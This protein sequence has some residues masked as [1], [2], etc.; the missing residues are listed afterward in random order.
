[1][2]GNPF[3][4]TVRHLDLP[5]RSPAIDVLCNNPFG[6]ILGESTGSR[7]SAHAHAQ[8]DTESGSLVFSSDHGRTLIKLVRLSALLRSRGNLANL[9]RNIAKKRCEQSE[10]FRGSAFAEFHSAGPLRRKRVHARKF[11]PCVKQSVLSF[12]NQNLSA[13]QR[14]CFRVMD[15]ESSRVARFPCFAIEDFAIRFRTKIDLFG[16]RITE[17]STPRRT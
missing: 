9:V 10:D 8:S 12:N 11:G 17:S 15:D 7:D 6:T 3:F 14:T 2:R 4:R 16:S 1:M 13:E 5:M